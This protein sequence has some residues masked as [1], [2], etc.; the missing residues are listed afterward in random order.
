MERLGGLV[1]LAFVPCRGGA[2]DAPLEVAAGGCARAGEHEHSLVMLMGKA[3]S[4]QHW[5][6][7]NDGIP[8]ESA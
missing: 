8:T 3:K 2:D 6:V 7:D 5:P 4:E 1:A